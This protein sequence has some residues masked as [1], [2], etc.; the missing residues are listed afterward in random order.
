[1]RWSSQFRYINNQSSFFTFI[2]L[3]S[4]P[5][6]FHLTSSMHTTVKHGHSLTI[7]P[8]ATMYMSRVPELSRAHFSW[9][10]PAKNLTQP[11]IADKKTDP[12]RSLILPHTY[13]LLPADAQGISPTEN[14]QGGGDATP[15]GFL[16][17]RPNFSKIFL[18]G[19]FSG[20][21]ESNGDNEKNSIFIAWPWKSRSNT[22]LHDLSYL[23]L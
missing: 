22:F 4:T 16:P 13:S 7:L 14:A 3:S 9:T 10:R 8:L 18:M 2:K 11:A 6:T 12:T 21:K 20:V 17:S 1:M 19:M 5:R 15:P 23:R